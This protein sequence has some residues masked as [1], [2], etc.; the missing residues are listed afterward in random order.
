MT[1]NVCAIALPFWIKARF[2]MRDH[3]LITQMGELYGIVF[4]WEMVAQS[5]RL[6]TIPVFHWLRKKRSGSPA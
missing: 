4:T 1:S 6:G 3:W 5:L 2:A